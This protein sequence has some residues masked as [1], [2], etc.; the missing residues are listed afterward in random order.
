MIVKIVSWFEI[1]LTSLFQDIKETLLDS[2]PNNKLSREEKLNKFTENSTTYLQ[3]LGVIILQLSSTWM[4]SKL[5][6]QF[7]KPK[8]SYT[9]KEIAFS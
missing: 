7:P 5:N 4:I 8:L 6:N 2:H 3:I 9:V 1:T